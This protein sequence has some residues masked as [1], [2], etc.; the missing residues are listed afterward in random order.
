METFVDDKKN[1]S[2][3]AR[4]IVIGKNV[5]FG[6]NI[7]VT[8]KGDF[9]LGDFSR[10][11]GDCQIFGNNVKFGA[12]LFNSSGL[13]IG[14]GGRQ[15]PSA[16]FE[17][18]DR[19]T[20]HNNFIN[21][22][23]PVKIGNDVGLSPDTSIMTHGYWLSVL[24]GYPA[25]FSGVSIGDGVIVGYRSLIMMG[26]SIADYCVVGAQSVVTKSLKEKGIYAGSPAKFIKEIVPLNSDQREEKV[27]HIIS[28]YYKIAEY[29]N[30]YQKLKLDYP[31]IY[32]KDFA[33]NVETFEYHGTEDDETDDLR[34]YI[35]KWGIRIYTER[36]FVA[37]FTF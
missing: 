4:S 17:I 2:I 3:K 20:I 1:I 30:I 27:N 33:F 25:T 19:C 21:V 10:L 26:V 36:P 12:H 11:G 34:D 28:E 15:H 29:H 14:G 23:E 16:N 6:N 7:K 24:E 9:A 37:K 13:R 32:F 5:Q 22:C 31:W 35:R 8:I 18:G